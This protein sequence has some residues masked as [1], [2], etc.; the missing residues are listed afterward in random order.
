MTGR[1]ADVRFPMSAF[2]RP[3]SGARL[4]PLC[5]LP[6]VRPAS[7]VLPASCRPACFLPSCLLFAVRLASRCPACFLPFGPLR[8]RSFSFFSRTLFAVSTLLLRTVPFAQPSTQSPARFWQIGLRL[9]INRSARRP[10]DLAAG[11]SGA[12]WRIR[13]RNGPLQPSGFRFT[14]TVAGRL[15]QQSRG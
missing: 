10:T 4:L 8:N 15:H 14:I 2:R 1:S 13:W 3:L 7:G 11:M 6:V 5:L 12:I 9:T